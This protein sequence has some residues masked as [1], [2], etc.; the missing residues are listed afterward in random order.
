MIKHILFELKWRREIILDGIKF[1]AKSIKMEHLCLVYVHFTSVISQNTNEWPFYTMW[2]WT[3]FPQEL[4]GQTS[5]VKELDKNQ[6]A[7]YDIVLE[8]RVIYPVLHLW[9]LLKHSSSMW[10]EGR[11]PLPRDEGVIKSWKS[12][13]NQKY[14]LGHFGKQQCATVS[15]SGNENSQSSEKQNI[16]FTSARTPQHLIPLWHQAILELN[17]I[18]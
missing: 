10:R 8:N 3:E 17:V 12:M 9:R 13:Q 2:M 14:C 7:F 15:L 1:K 16:L 5:W 18:N 6:A 11:L 4:Q